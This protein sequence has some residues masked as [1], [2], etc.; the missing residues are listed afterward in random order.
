MRRHKA[1]VVTLVLTG[2]LTVNHHWSST[3]FGRNGHM[4]P[5]V[6][7]LSNLRRIT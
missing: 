5:P 2:L 3:A 7:K 6:S 4:S 1:W